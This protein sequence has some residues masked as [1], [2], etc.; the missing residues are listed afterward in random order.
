MFSGIAVYT[1]A[2][3]YA[4]TVVDLND[5]NEENMKYNINQRHAAYL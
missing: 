5:Y 4:Q 2:R 1:L 3:S